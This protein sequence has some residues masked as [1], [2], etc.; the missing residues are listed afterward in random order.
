MDSQQQELE[1]TNYSESSSSAKCLGGL[2][3]SLTED[4]YYSADEDFQLENE[5]VVNTSL[6]APGGRFPSSNWSNGLK[7]FGHSDQILKSD[8]S[9]SKS[10]FSSGPENRFQDNVKGKGRIQGS[11]CQL[12]KSETERDSCRACEVDTNSSL[13]VVS[14]SEDNISEFSVL[15]DSEVLSLPSEKQNS[16]LLRASRVGNVQLVRQLVASSK[17]NAN[18]TNENGFSSLHWA[19]LKGHSKVVEE[20]LGANANPNSENLMLCTPLHFSAGCGFDEIVGKLLKAGANPNSVS[21]LGHTP[22]FSAACMG[23]ENTVKTLLKNGAD[24]SIRN[25][26]GLTPEDAAESHRHSD[27][28]KILQGARMH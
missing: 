5:E 21:A 4:C 23:H 28:V 25:K 22:L 20:L 14:S 24:P 15:S 17:F 26:Q 13:S 12:D 8:S 19:S 10:D 1:G 6:I 3:G 7:S 27:I 11:T 2:K 16:L 18:A 9:R